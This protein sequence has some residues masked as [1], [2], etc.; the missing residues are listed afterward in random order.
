[1]DWAGHCV[2]FPLGWAVLK[3][4]SGRI[5]LPCPHILATTFNNQ[6]TKIN[7]SRP[8]HLSTTHRTGTHRPTTT[9]RRG[10]RRRPNHFPIPYRSRNFHLFYLKQRRRL[11][12]RNRLPCL[13]RRLLSSE[14]NRPPDTGWVLGV[15]PASCVGRCASWLGLGSIKTATAIFR[16]ACSWSGMPTQNPN[17]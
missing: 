12:S 9:H 8:C 3:T 16:Q 15:F 10:H 5:A 6:W 1:M 14:R 13:L 7:R 2:D 17:F 4:A 11:L